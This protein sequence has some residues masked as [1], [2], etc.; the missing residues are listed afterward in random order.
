MEGI[1]FTKRAYQRIRHGSTYS[2]SLA[3]GWDLDQ[4]VSSLNRR[5]LQC[6]LCI[7][8]E[9]GTNCEWVS[10]GI[11]VNLCLGCGVS[12]GRV[13]PCPAESRGHL[14]LLRNISAHPITTELDWM[15][16]L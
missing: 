4:S 10:V 6:T 5:P 12:E 7:S 11:S 16:S 15:M 8:S 3:Q 14:S 2:S 13:G 9:R 1:A